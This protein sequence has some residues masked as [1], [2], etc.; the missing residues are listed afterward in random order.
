[1]VAGWPYVSWSTRFLPPSPPPVSQR[2]KQ[3]IVVSCTP[4]FVLVV[5]PMHVWYDMMSCNVYRCSM[6]TQNGRKIENIKYQKKKKKLQ[7][8]SDKI[9]K[10]AL[11]FLNCSKPPFSP[12]LLLLYCCCM[13]IP[14][15]KCSVLY[16]LYL[17]RTERVLRIYHNSETGAGICSPPLG[18]ASNS[19]SMSIFHF[20][21]STRTLW[22]FSID[23]LVTR[24]IHFT[25]TYPLPP[26][27]ESEPLVTKQAHIIQQREKNQNYSNIQ[28][29]EVIM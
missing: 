4:C 25:S 3:A 15:T 29:S 11:Q 13:N 18:P 6:Q 19:I 26:E 16:T 1:M 5:L 20:R 27:Y 17:V 28:H 24:P 10:I 8:A 23:V 14:C 7:A 9:V 21:Y 12:F 22:Y 2:G